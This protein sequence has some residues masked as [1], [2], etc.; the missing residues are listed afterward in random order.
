M[1]H[2]RIF[3]ETLNLDHSL[4][5][6]SN[7]AKQIGQNVKLHIKLLPFGA[8]P[9][10]CGVYTS[11]TRRNCKC[12]MQIAHLIF[13]YVFTIC[14]FLFFISGERTQVIIMFFCTDFHL[15]LLGI[16][17]FYFLFFRQWWPTKNA[18]ALF[19]GPFDPG[20]WTMPWDECSTL[21]VQTF[22]LCCH[23]H[24]LWWQGYYIYNH[25]TTWLCLHDFVCKILLRTLQKLY[26]L[27]GENKKVNVGFWP[28]Q[29]LA[30][31]TSRR[32]SSK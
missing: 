21:L 1:L 12:Q 10:W 16:R 11:I 13:R 24:L 7:E 25:V 22:V 23:C 19:M 14:K 30:C 6:G 5:H 27:L 18:K 20:H 3:G 8:I 4:S 15:H 26:L 29:L 9:W 28:R 17:N 2:H 32:W 31:C